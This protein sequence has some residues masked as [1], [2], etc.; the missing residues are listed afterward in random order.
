MILTVIGCREFCY[1]VA[2]EDGQGEWS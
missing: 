2:R 1:A